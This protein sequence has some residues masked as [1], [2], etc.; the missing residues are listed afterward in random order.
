MSTSNNTLYL[1]STSSEVKICNAEHITKA[2]MLQAL[3]LVEYSHFFFFFKSVEEDNKCFKMMSPD[4]KIAERYQQSSRQI[5]YVIQHG[6]A[7]YICDLVK[8]NFRNNPFSFF[9]NETTASHVKNSLAGM[10]QYWSFD[11]N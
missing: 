8:T 5:K 2:E 11:K 1:A 3:K 10:C 4:S 9:L 6:L 7:P